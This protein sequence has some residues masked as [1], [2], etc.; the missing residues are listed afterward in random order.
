MDYFIVKKNGQEVKALSDEQLSWLLVPPSPDTPD[1]ESRKKFLSNLHSHGQWIRCGCNGKAILYIGQSAAPYVYSRTDSKHA[2]HE[3]FCALKPGEKSKQGNPP[4]PLSEDKGFNLQPKPKEPSNPKRQRANGNVTSN[5]RRRENPFFRLIRGMFLKAKLNQ[6][7]NGKKSVYSDQKDALLKAAATFNIDNNVT[8]R[9]ALLFNLPEAKIREHIFAIKDKFEKNYPMAICFWIADSY[10]ESDG[11]YTLKFGNNLP[12]ITIKAKDTD[13]KDMHS[14][15]SNQNGPFLF[16]AIRSLLPKGDGSGQAG[17]FFTKML[18]IPIL[19]LEY[20]M[21][22]D[23]N[24]ERVCGTQLIASARYWHSKGKVE[25][26]ISKPLEDFESGGRS[27]RPD[28]EIL[29]DEKRQFLEVMGL[30]NE[31]YRAQ[32]ALQVPA[33]EATAPVKSFIAFNLTS[34]E[35]KERAFHFV[36]NIF[37]EHLKRA[38]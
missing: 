2:D 35:L 18:I 5:S 24:N 38:D 16:A 1:F 7:E 6:V 26:V 14:F 8:A 15:G 33:M 4:K 32:K 19:S 12:D 29:L 9:E 25:S 34:E 21:F 31:T 28:F 37:I 13:V 17:F 10:K 22:V 20:W 3:D 11:I 23:S 30:D 27:V 36:K